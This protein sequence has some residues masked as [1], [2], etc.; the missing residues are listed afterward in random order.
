MGI[1]RLQKKEELVEELA[2][3]GALKKFFKDI[4]Q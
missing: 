4:R 1:S 3:V 2:V